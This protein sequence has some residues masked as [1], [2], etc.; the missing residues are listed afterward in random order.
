[1]ASWKCANPEYLRTVENGNQI[2]MYR[3]RISETPCNILTVSQGMNQDSLKKAL[4]QYSLIDE[5]YKNYLTDLFQYLLT[6]QSRFFNK[7]YTPE[8]YVKFVIHNFN[9]LPIVEGDS[10][11]EHTCTLNPVDIILKNGKIYMNWS[12][13]L[14]NIIDFQLEENNTP[15]AAPISTEVAE[16]LEVNDV[17]N[18]GNADDTNEIVAIRS[19]QSGGQSMSDKQFRDR[20]RV[21]E[22]RLRAKLAAVRAERAL[23]RYVHKY[24][25]YDSDETSADE[26]T[27]TEFDSE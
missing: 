12:V 19:G 1:M 26:M 22:A 11:T 23:E 24:G 17:D 2:F 14:A 4:L 15:E 13:E 18:T 21:E 7:K 10:T 3:F 8:Q 20:Q 25:D 5:E 16:I 27:E 9:N 6:T